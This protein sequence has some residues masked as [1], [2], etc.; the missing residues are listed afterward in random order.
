MPQAGRTALALPSFLWMTLLT[1]ALVLRGCGDQEAGPGGDARDSAGDPALDGDSDE[2]GDTAGHD[3][4]PAD[5]GM[6]D[7]LSDAQGEVAPSDATTEDSDTADLVAD[8]DALA[9]V[10]DT[11]ADDDGNGDLA[12]AS[13]GADEAEDGDGEGGGDDAGDTGDDVAEAD[14]GES[15]VPQQ[16][17]PGTGHHRPGQDCLS[18]HASAPA[19]RRWTLAGTLYDSA[20]GNQP[21]VGA[22]VIVVDDNALERRIVTADNGNFWTLEPLAYPVDVTVSRCPDEVTMPVAAPSGSC[23]TSGCHDSGSRIH[24]P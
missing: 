19:A 9:D 18:C 15:C 22:T 1:M 21:V 12:D 7:L 11:P 23:N 13:D 20:A 10:A 14:G 8:S 2:S 4:P 16:P 17:S 5:F 24:L 3:L 6:E